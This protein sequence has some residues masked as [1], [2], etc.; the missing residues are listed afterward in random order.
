[1]ITFLRSEPRL[2]EKNTADWVQS[3]LFSPQIVTMYHE[4]LAKSL[5][6]YLAISLKLRC[7]RSEAGIAHL[8]DSNHSED[9]N[10]LDSVGAGIT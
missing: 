6:H 8:S 10:P 7:T 1:M 3:L 4:Y 2:F 9:L 5:H